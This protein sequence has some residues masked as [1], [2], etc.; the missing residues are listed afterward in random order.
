MA[1]ATSDDL[2]KAV[3]TAF[4]QVKTSLLA[5]LGAGNLASHAVVDAVNKAKE[6]VTESS[7]AAR[8]NI[9]EL[10]SDVDSLRERFEPAE[11]RKLLDEY[12]EAALKLYHKL[13]ESGEETWERLREQP[14]VRRS[15]EQLEEVLQT[16]QE[17]VGDVT[18]DAR[19]RV[20]EVLARVTGRTR[21]V[22]EDTA[23]KMEDAAAKVE[24]VTSEVADKVEE[25]SPASPKTTTKA[26]PRTASARKTSSSTSSS[27]RKS[28]GGNSK[29]TK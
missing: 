10:P 1:T 19:E 11:L 2:R 23:L 9:E 21:E 7:D 17:R 20:D 27:T 16:A 26:T 25:T 29:S 15:I 24:E 3:N 8:K 6:R 28:T 22:G 14:Q 12:T 4:E 13:A 18:G 5:A